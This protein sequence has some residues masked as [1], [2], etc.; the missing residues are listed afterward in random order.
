MLLVVSRDLKSVPASALCH[1]PEW[2]IREFY[3]C[4]THSTNL[5]L[6][7]SMGQDGLIL[8]LNT[9]IHWCDEFA[10]W[11]L[12]RWVR[13]YGPV[14]ALPPLYSPDPGLPNVYPLDEPPMLWTN[15]EYTA[16]VSDDDV[17]EIGCPAMTLV[18]TSHLEVKANSSQISLTNN[19]YIQ[20]I[21]IDVDTKNSSGAKSNEAAEMG[22]TKVTPSKKTKKAKEDAKDDDNSSSDGC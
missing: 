7:F 17:S 18:T 15:S 5:V 12:H 8:H 14:T 19:E 10:V 4:S 21:T 20:Y 6:P 11:R 1:L 13:P 16:A 2:S 3:P 9:P 22:N